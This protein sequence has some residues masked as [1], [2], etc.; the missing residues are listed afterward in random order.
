MNRFAV[1]VALVVLP[2]AG[3]DKKK[4]S[5]GLP[6]AGKWGSAGAGASG[7]GGGAATDPH[8]G[9]DVGGGADPH[10][11]LDMGGAADPHAGLD[12]GG[13]ADPHA[14]VDMSGGAGSANPHGG[15]DMAGIRQPD[16]AHFIKGTVTIDP[17]LAGKVPPGAVLFLA[18]KTPDPNGQPV[19]MPLMSQRFEQVDLTKPFAFDLNEGNS[20]MGNVPVLEGD[21]FVTV[22][23]D[24][25]SNATT[26]QPGD[27]SAQVKTTVPQKDLKVVVDTVV[28]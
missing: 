27:L 20:Q 23:V 25:D 19:R 13:A 4:D 24:Q 22:F 3:C 12:M 5:G 18:V 6:P 8:A 1:L 21:V 11:G 7:G 15:A 17:K 2:L 28:P 26:H 9:L 16:P 14:G 10:A